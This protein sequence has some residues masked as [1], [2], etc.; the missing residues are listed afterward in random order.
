MG[1][2]ADELIGNDKTEDKPLMPLLS[3]D[4]LLPIHGPAYVTATDVLTASG[5]FTPLEG[6]GTL[7]LSK[8]RA[9]TPS[10]AP[11]W[12]ILTCSPLNCEQT[13]RM[14]V[15]GGWLYR[16]KVGS[17]LAMTFAPDYR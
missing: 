11:Q 3:G 8:M 2:I 15:E 16:T 12:Q 6:S 7:T 17:T 14:R 1:F 5:C 4:E 9:Y 10:S 13:D